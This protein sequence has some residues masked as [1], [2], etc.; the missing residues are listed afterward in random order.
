MH[1]TTDVFDCAFGH[2]HFA[3]PAFLG[4][5]FR[6]F[7]THGRFLTFNKRSNRGKTRRVGV[8]AGEV[9]EEIT[10]GVNAEFVEA[11]LGRV[12]ESDEGGDGGGESKHGSIVQEKC[13]LLETYSRLHNMKL[14]P[15]QRAED[16][17]VYLGLSWEYL[18]GKTILDV[19]A[20]PA[21]L[22][23]TALTHGISIVCVDKVEPEEGIP[24]GVHY[25][26]ADARKM[27]FRDTSFDLVVAIGVLTDMEGVRKPRVATRIF[28]EIKRVFKKDGEY[29]FGLGVGD[30]AYMHTIDPHIRMRLACI[31]TKE[32]PRYSYVYKKVI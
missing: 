31:D 15:I 28:R 32:R 3:L 12:L 9:V 20:G 1:G 4:G 6:E 26:V 7:A 27:P 11:K 21:D 29:H 22:A 23:H 25:V 17:L 2:W 5:K 24:T 18:K 16:I 14:D 8:A 19:G 10:D 30:Q 13:L